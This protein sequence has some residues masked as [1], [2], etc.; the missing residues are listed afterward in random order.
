MQTDPH[1]PSLPH[2]PGEEEQPSNFG[3][4][5]EILGLRGA[6]A[7]D[8]SALDMHAAIHKGLSFTS[9][10]RVAERAGLPISGAAKILGLPE[11]TV[12]R[13][14]ERGQK[15]TP[16]ESERVARLA[17]VIVRANEVL[18]DNEKARSWLLR[19]NR[20]LGCEPAS[21]LDTDVGTEAVLDV[22]GRIEHGVIS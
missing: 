12:L 10:S 16:L 19:H 4:V 1:T 9:L 2:D 17:R 14:K 20:A 15:F 22:L 18:G 21:L 8:A 3:G 5:F 7:R 6:Q 11:R 13:R